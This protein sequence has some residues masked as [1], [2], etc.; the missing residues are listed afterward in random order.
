MTE[1]SKALELPAPAKLNLFLHIIGRRPNGY[2]ELQTVF[3]LLDYSDQIRLVFR[4]DGVISRSDDSEAQRNDI[5]FD[6]DLCVR[7]AKL[8][9]QEMYQI[10]TSKTEDK[11]LGVEIH[12]LKKLPIGG[13]IGG[14]SSDAATVLLGLNKLWECNLSIDKLAELSVQ[15]GADLPVFIRGNSAWAEGIGERLT[16]LE[17][18]SKWFVVIHPNIFVSTSK[19]FADKGLTRDSDTFT[20]ARFLRDDQIDYLDPEFSNVFE[21]VVSKKYPVIANAI[22]W[23]SKYSQARLTGTGSCV[24]ASFDSENKA[25]KVLEDLKNSNHN[26]RG[27]VSKGVNN[28]P[29][30]IALLD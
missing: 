25:L 13:G 24:F 3:Q 5:P 10:K 2:H 6:N 1:C 12:L 26:W 9:Q 11:L 20:I 8:I 27:F 16:P 23:L 19:I 28:S 15:L 21:S 4:E 7:A 18:P 29:A 17:L 14:G 22:N 30:H